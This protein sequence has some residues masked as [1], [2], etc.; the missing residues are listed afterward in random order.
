MYSNA[1]L[2]AMTVSMTINYSNS[3]YRYAECHYSEFYQ[4][5]LTEK[6]RLSTVD[7]LSRGS[8]FVKK[9]IMFSNAKATDIN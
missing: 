2:S 5:I 6:G 4:G 8:L 9:Y 3:Q 1:S 7:L